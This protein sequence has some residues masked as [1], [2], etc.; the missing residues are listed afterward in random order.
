VATV[1][2]KSALPPWR[3]TVE[4]HQSG[5]RL[6]RWLVSRFPDRSRSTL[7]KW[8]ERGLVLIDGVTVRPSASVRSG[9]IVEVEIPPP[10]PTMPLPEDFPLDLIHE[11]EHLLIIDKPAGMVVHPSPGSPP[12]GT[13]VNALLGHTERLSRVGG[14]NR[15]GIVHRLDR[16]TSGVIAVAKTDEAH[17]A[18][19][20]QFHERE[21]SKEYLALAHG[22]PRTVTGEIDLPL[23]RSTGDPRKQGV[24]HDSGGRE[25]FTSW[26]KIATLPALT[27]LRCFP[28]TGRTHQIRVHLRAIG[29]PILCDKFYGREKS[30]NLC[31]YLPGTSSAPLERHALH[32]WRLFFHHPVEGTPMRFHAP[33]PADLRPF[34]VASVPLEGA[35]EE[36]NPP[37]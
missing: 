12:E 5:L 14:E 33:L 35:L 19:S 3:S 17:R 25:S 34:W 29:H 22:C 24:R 9:Q 6:D 4:D 26:Q 10:L 28:R 1:A 31:N 23:G 11:D 27:W 7:Q 32:A 37:P 13:L 8:I 36:G 21:V 2:E 30:A 15:A 16:E 20:A 18:L